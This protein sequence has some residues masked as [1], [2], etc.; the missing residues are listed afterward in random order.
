MRTYIK[1]DVV[2]KVYSQLGEEVGDIKQVSTI[3]NETFRALREIMSQDN[4]ECRIE[5]R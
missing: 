4:S 1:K 3:V 5:I 2:E